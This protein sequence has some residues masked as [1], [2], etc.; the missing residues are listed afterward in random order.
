MCCVHTCGMCVVCI[1]RVG[2]SSLVCVCVLVCA[3]R[4][5]VR[6][7]F[8]GRPVARA[9]SQLKVGGAF[10]GGLWAGR[11]AG[12]GWAEKAGDRAAVVGTKGT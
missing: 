7:G 8:L 1:V 6:E 5:V 12:G 2:C 9:V 3:R 4:A 11:K 10:P